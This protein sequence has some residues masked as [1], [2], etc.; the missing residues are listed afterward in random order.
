MQTITSMNYERI[1]LKNLY[2]FVLMDLN[3]PVMNGFDSCKEIFH[4][5]SSKRM[6]KLENIQGG[7]DYEIDITHLRPLIIACTA[8][9]LL[10]P[11]ACKIA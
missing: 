7:K 8:E 2:Q 5:F 9:I 3:M 11:M 10:S 4:F 6:V 1:E